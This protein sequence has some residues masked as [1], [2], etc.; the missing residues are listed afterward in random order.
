[1]A[2]YSIKELEKLSG[3]KAH[4]IRIWEQR[5][6]LLE[7]QRTDTNIRKYDDASLKKLLNVATLLRY[8]NKISRIAALTDESLQNLVLEHTEERPG[9][10]DVID[11]LVV[12]MIEL[13]EKR[14]VEI[15]G[16]ALKL[17]GPESVY[18]EVIYPF[19]EKIGILWQAGAINPAQEHFISCIIRQKLIAAIDELDETWESEKDAFLLFLPENE[20]HELG[21]L[22]CY[23]ILKKRGYPV[24]YLGP[25]VPIQDLEE[26]AKIRQPE[27]ML[28]AYVNPVS[29]SELKSQLYYLQKEFPQIDIYV[30]GYQTVAND[31]QSF[32][33]VHILRRITDL[34][35]SV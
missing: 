14:F 22:F 8:G 16:Q 19:L 9:V 20:M 31:I 12:N 6:Q 5:Y 4:T 35:E 29:K 17:H 2:S 32:E 26:V 25:N 34:L 7:P 33:K 27:A 30:N 11:K 28:T 23:Y 1:M 21:L 18:L 13:N 24:I 3:V 10:E 15:F